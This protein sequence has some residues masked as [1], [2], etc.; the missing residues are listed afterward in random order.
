MGLPHQRLMLQGFAAKSGW[1][2]LMCF[3]A[4]E[5]QTE[6]TNPS[7]LFFTLCEVIKSTKV[8]HLYICFNLGINGK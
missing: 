8:G 7:M 1:V 3:Q 6:Q 2:M 4:F 5:S